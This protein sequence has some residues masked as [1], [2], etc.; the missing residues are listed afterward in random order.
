MSV[1]SILRQSTNSSGGVPRTL[2]VGGGL[3]VGLST[4]LGLAV[5]FILPSSSSYVSGFLL[6]ILGFCFIVGGISYFAGK[7]L[8][9]RKSS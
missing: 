2:S 3:T 4:G 6:L 8:S 9:R 5:L 1:V 7:L